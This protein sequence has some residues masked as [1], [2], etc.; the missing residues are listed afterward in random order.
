[1]SLKRKSKQANS[2]NINTTVCT[3]S[4]VSP[5]QFLGVQTQEREHRQ[6]CLDPSPDSSSWP[7]SKLY[8]T[9]PTPSHIPSAQFL[10]ST[11]MTPCPL[12]F[13]LEFQ[14][15]AVKSDHDTC[16]LCIQRKRKCRWGLPFPFAATTPPLWSLQI[17]VWYSGKC[18]R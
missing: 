2:S 1:M 15:Q 18:K 6:L 17:C 7:G 10:L 8:H 13:P 4:F 9:G 11:S 3:P 16:L 12:A 5:F 14:T